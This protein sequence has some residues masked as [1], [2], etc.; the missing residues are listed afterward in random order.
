MKK[1]SYHQNFWL[2]NL[3]FIMEDI[4]LRMPHILE[5]VNEFLD[6]KSLVKCKGVSR[7]MYSIIEH[8]KFATTRV[9]KSYTKNSKKFAKYWRIVF[10]KLSLERLNELLIL[11][12]EFYKTVPS[13]LEGNWSPMHVVAER[14]HIDFCKSIA[15]LST[16][17]SYEWPP[18]N[19]SVQG[20]HLEVTKFLYEEFQEKQD[21]RIFEIALHLAAKNGHLEIY[22]FL[23]E[24]L[25][26]INPEMQ[27]D[28]TPLHLAAQYGCFEVCKYIC[29]NATFIAPFRS[30]KNTPLTLAVHRSHIKIARLLHERDDHSPLWPLIVI[31]FKMYCMFLG[32]FIVYDILCYTFSGV[33][34]I[35]HNPMLFVCFIILFCPPHPFLFGVIAVISNIL[36]DMKFCFWTSPNLDY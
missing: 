1:Y 32:S 15:K 17:K 3:D 13:R 11:V 18:I 28:I 16:I 4:C 5:Q 25:D 9:I 24:N 8:Q 36:K 34:I 2:G 19:F 23:H 27:E 7:M 31:L 21:G 10:Q 20:G 12:K 30:D 35:Y 29:D 33:S 6:D 14:G 22:K 26:E